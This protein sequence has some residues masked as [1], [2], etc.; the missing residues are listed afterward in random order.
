M[1]FRICRGNVFL[2]TAEI[3]EPLEDPTT[4][5]IFITFLFFGI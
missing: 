5:K 1:L 4:V 2:R 3:E